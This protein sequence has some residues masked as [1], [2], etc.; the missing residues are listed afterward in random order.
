VKA[1]PVTTSAI[2]AA[3]ATWRGARPISDA[4]NSA[5]PMSMVCRLARPR[6]AEKS[7]PTSAPKPKSAGEDAEDLGPAVER[8]RGEDRGEAR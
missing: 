6:D 2:P 5:A 4:E 8:A 7:A 1:M 3:H